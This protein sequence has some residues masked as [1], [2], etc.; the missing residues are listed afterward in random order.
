MVEPILTAV[1]TDVFLARLKKE[2]K[3]PALIESTRAD[4]PAPEWPN[5]FTFILDNDTPLGISCWMY[6]SLVCSYLERIMENFSI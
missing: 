3:Y 1:A 4:F 5:N 2:E 6:S